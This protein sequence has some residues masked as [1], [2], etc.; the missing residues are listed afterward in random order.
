MLTHRASTILG[1]LPPDWD[2]E[3]LVNLLSRQ[4]G[5]DWGEDSG[6]V[7]IRV[8]R[9]TNFTNT[10]TLNLDDVEIRYFPATKAS[11]FALTDGDILVERS[12]GGPTQPVGR[13]GFISCRLPN[14]WFSNFVQLL[15]PDSSKVDPEFLGWLLLEL[16]RSGLVERLQHQ[17]TQ[18]RN[19]DFRDYL[20]IFLPTPKSEEQRSVARILRA[21]SDLQ[22]AAEAKLTASYRLKTALIQQLFTRGIPGRHTRFKMTKIGEIPEQWE[23]TRISSIIASDIYN[24]VSPQS[25]PEPPGTPILN[26]GCVSD[27]VCDPNKVTYV[28]LDESPSEDLLAGRGDFY[29]LRGN[30]NR[31]FI[32][33]GG[34]LVDNP[35]ENCVFS[36]L[37]IKI[38]FDHTKTIEGFMPMLWQSRSFLRS[39]QSKA[40][41]GSGLWKIGLRE[42]RR[43]EFAQPPKSEQSEI[44]E[45]L[46]ACDES[47]QACQSEVSEIERLKQSLLQNLLTGR[48][49]WKV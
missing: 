35:P 27:G 24:G 5:G 23:V 48:V 12:G 36:D 45:I 32:A 4:Q 16:N 17:T 34:L 13:I 42:I 47:V 49:K 44:V 8:V 14:Y 38:S 31:E 9:S 6:E 43:H 41:S 26:V 20:R 1:N 22:I 19:L 3:M 46:R 30:G 11:E 10:G 7:S 2:R 25:R 37:L 39:V 21:A 29:I 15:R 18:M 40:V 28:D 33:T